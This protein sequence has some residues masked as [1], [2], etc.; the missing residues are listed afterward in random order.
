MTGV[1]TCALPISV[2]LPIPV[3]ESG[4]FI[5]KITYIQRGTP[6]ERARIYSLPRNDPKLKEKWE[7]L[8]KKRRKQNGEL[9][10]PLPDS[11]NLIGFV[12]TGN[13]NL[14]EGKGVAIGS[15]G[16]RATMAKEGGGFLGRICIVRDV[17]ST[18]GR[19]ARWEVL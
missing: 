19:L 7:S 18:V 4:L 5:V 13:F 1:Q 2:T 14:K 8:L 9:H 6:L 3:L 12:T 17:G 10:L 16:L 15:L 11:R